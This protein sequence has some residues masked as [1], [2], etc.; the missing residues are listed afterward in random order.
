MWLEKC[1]QLETWLASLGVEWTRVEKV[2]MVH[3]IGGWDKPQANDVRPTAILKSESKA[4]SEAFVRGD[5][6]PCPILFQRPNGYEIVDGRQRIFGARLVGEKDFPAI[7]LSPNTNERMIA[8]IALES[9]ALHGTKPQEAFRIEKALDFHVEYKNTEKDAAIMAGA[10]LSTFKTAKKTR[11][12]RTALLEYGYETTVA[13]G[14]LAA[15]APFVKE[16][17]ALLAAVQLVESADA[18]GEM[19][20]GLAEAMSKNPGDG[21]LD[22]IEQTRKKADWQTRIRHKEGAKRPVVI[23]AT[24]S[25]AGLVTILT[26]DADALREQMKSADK[27]QFA[28]LGKKIYAK[29]RDF[30][31]DFWSS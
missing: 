16:R 15:F 19:A 7:V 23:K 20:R 10:P 3:L 13:N 27:E 26:K 28:K 21:R 31:G 14:S 4:I 29:V 2:T 24:S 22:A 18:T 5:S 1:E 30:A 12:V 9:H 11:Q 17:G 8:H 25:M 6:F